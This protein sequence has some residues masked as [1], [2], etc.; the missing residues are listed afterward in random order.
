MNWTFLRQV[1]YLGLVALTTSAVT[2]FLSMYLLYQVSDSIKKES[3]L[4]ELSNDYFYLLAVFFVVA[5]LSRKVVARFTTNI[6]YKVRIQLLE[7]ISNS[8]YSSVEAT[9]K[10]RLFNMLSVDVNNISAALANLPQ[11]IYNVI[12]CISVLI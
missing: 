2:A 12:L 5:I 1:K 3:T 4:I 9:G 10:T 7:Q 8:E 11:F 6:I